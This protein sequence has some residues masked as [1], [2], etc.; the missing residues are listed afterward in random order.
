MCG[1]SRSFL[2]SQWWIDI[3]LN[4]V[5]LRHRLTLKLLKEHYNHRLKGIYHK[6][7]TI[8][9]PA[10]MI[11]FVII[12]MHWVIALALGHIK[13]IHEIT[14]RHFVILFILPSPFWQGIFCS[15]VFVITILFINER[16]HIHIFPLHTFLFL[17]FLLS[18]EQVVNLSTSKV[19]LAVG[20]LDHELKA[21]VQDKFKAETKVYQIS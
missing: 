9:R 1:A 14:T 17:I 2:L 13:Q 16:L 5:V 18:L 7:W 15:L 21:W 20:N 4:I 8:K 6:G 12:G 3:C 10:L 19:P 11:I